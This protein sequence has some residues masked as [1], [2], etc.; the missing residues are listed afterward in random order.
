MAAPLA[1]RERALEQV[2]ALLESAVSGRGRALFVL[3][4]AGLG[5]TTLLEHAVELASGRMAIGIGR[6]DVAEAA[7]PFGLLGQAL[8]P[9]LGGDV[10]RPAGGRRARYQ[11][12]ADR[13]YAILLRLREV[14]VSPLLIALD[15]AHW[16]DPDSLTLLRLIC[17]RL[18]GLPVGVIV[19]ARPWPPELARAAEELAEEGLVDVERLLP[20][21]TGAATALLGQR[22][23][24]RARPQDIETAVASCGGNPLLLIRVAA[25]L[26]AGRT[27]PDSGGQATG[28][29]ADRLLLSRFTGVGPTGEAYLRAASVLG[30]RFRPEVAAEVAGLG[31]TEAADA[32][33]ALVGAGL[34][35]EAGDGWV[36]FSHHLVRLA[37]YDQVAPQ[38]A[39]LHEA[40]FRVLLSRRAPAA[41]VAEHA[42][43]AR[44]AE[45]AAREVL[46]RAGR[47]ALR[48]GAPGTAIRHLRA[49]VELSGDETPADVLLDLAQA[50]RAVGD[51]EEAGAVCEE[52]LRRDELPVR[53]RL[54]ALTELA[55]A[56]F[57]AGYLEEATARMDQAVGMIGSEASELAATALL[58]QAHL[59]VLRL[60]PRTA[61]P[62]AR[63]ARMLA[64]QVGGQTRVVADAVWAECAYLSGDPEG[65]EVAE[66]AAKEARLVSAPIPEA[67]QWSDPQVL[68]A[69][70]AMSSERFA[71]AEGILAEIVREAEQKRHPMNLFEGQYLL[72][73]V[74]R[75]TGRLAEATNLAE[76]LLGS[77]EL[78]PFALPLA[79]AEKILV[80]LDL[81][82]LDEA[83]QCCQQLD[84]MTAGKARLGRVWSLAHL[85]RALLAWRQGQVEEASRI[86]GLL[87]RSARLVDLLEPCIYPWAH[88]A[89]A[90]HLACDRDDDA[91]RVID[92]LAPRAEVLPARWPKAVVEGA[93]AA[94]A[95]RQGD[96]DRAEAAFAQAA[97]MHNPG[98]P[99]ARAESF[100][101]FGTF[102]IRHQNP[103]RA[104]PVLAE[105]V[106]LA[107]ACGATWHAE[108]ARVAWRRAGG[109]ARATPAGTLTP[110]EKA[111]ADLAKAGRTNREI[112]VQL[113]L[114]V[115]TV[116]TH[117]SHIYRKLGISGRWQLIAGE[118]TT[119]SQ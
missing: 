26:E 67:T 49:L 83:L 90:A 97:S 9:L 103:S 116:E 77:A 107:E 31:P 29:W 111:V 22:I 25:E 56:E 13:L 46:A 92:W 10:L 79:V 72:V 36:M 27:L 51:N 110:Q 57:R 11:P 106:Q 74:L 68:Y 37:V 54:A 65:L 104:R 82:Q 20:L 91:A 33:G 38:Q 44:L 70:L 112:A 4:E 86:F 23:R 48:Q 41:Q 60:G 96:L 71:E 73:E 1:E 75:R 12:A 66:R 89:V 14:A 102:L 53:L 43:A 61:L 93:R 59:T 105:A 5:K 45:P 16:A 3:G 101:D 63:R 40:A 8:E 15:D 32:L 76:E 21:S 80:L 7:L 55:Q 17:R 19:T 47:E 84:K 119:A 35:V 78:M 117:L 114:S 100:T 52:L 113:Y 108:R 95:E 99:L 62:L 6:A 115:N 2:R 85:D 118:G 24:D 94:L 50:L 64:V 30:L 28:S 87:E 81:G 34:V 39:H 88:P 42:M 98:M 109:R 58:D 18:A 69:E